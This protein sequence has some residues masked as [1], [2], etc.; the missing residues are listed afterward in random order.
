MK[1]CSVTQARVHWHDLGSLQPLPPGFKQFFCL[2]LLSSW[3]YRCMPPRLANFCIFSRDGVLPCWSG[4]SQTPDFMIWPPRS[5]KSFAFVAQS[6]VQ[7]HTVTSASWVLVI[8][9]PQP[10]K[11]SLTLSPRLECS[12]AISAH[13]NL[14]LLNSSNSPASASQVA[15]T[16][17][18]HHT[19]IIYVFLVETG[20]T[21]LARLVSN[22]R[23]QVIH[24]PRPPKVLRLQCEPS[25]LDCNQLPL[26]HFKGENVQGLLATVQGLALLLRPACSGAITADC[27]LNLPGSSN[28]PAS[29][30]QDEISQ[31]RSLFMWNLVGIRKRHLLVGHSSV[32]AQPSKSWDYRHTPHTWLIFKVSLDTRTLYVAQ[33][34]LKLLAL[35]SPLALVSQSAGIICVSHHAQPKYP[36]SVASLIL[37]TR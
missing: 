13:C 3:D 32:D 6:G 1:S 19:W 25:C 36:F 20:F 16:T 11:W 28:P 31:D 17:G 18:T 14:H 27:G 29:A 24:L 23:P 7:C 22:S 34:G 12:G 4:W 5:P 37:S 8:L 35:S 21:T 2:S 30:S 26:K 33:A 15:W 9:L 10:P